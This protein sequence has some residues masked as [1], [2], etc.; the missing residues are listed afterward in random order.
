MD[1]LEQYKDMMSERQRT[2]DKKRR[3]AEEVVSVNGDISTSKLEL[4]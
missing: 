4:C 1:S 3:T 2:I